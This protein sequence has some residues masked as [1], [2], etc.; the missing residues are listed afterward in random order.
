MIRKIEIKNDILKQ[1][2]VFKDQLSKKALEFE[3]QGEKLIKQSEEIKKKFDQIQEES[4]KIVARAC[5]EDEKARPEFERVIKDIDLGEWEEVDRVELATKE[6]GY[7]NKDRGKTF[8]IIVD[9]VEEFKKI[10]KERQ[11]KKNEE[12]NNG[13]DAAS[14]G[15]GLPT[16]RTESP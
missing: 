13:G 3:E 12:K 6:K 14:D 8:L 15:G 7:D 11:A 16:D 4:N 2:V 9:R 10:H 5:R 1:T